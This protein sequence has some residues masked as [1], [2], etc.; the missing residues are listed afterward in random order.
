MAAIFG[1]DRWE[2]A[3]GA[4]PSDDWLL[5][6]GHCTLAD[7]ARGIERCERDD[8]GRLPSLG[9]FKSMCREFQSGTFAGASKPMPAG[10]LPALADMCSRSAKG[11]QWHAYM[12]LR[13]IVPMGD[14][15]MDDLDR[16]LDGCDIDDMD[17]RVAAVEPM[18]RAR[19]MRT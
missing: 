7:I 16:D 13:G 14:S 5:A 18:I 2:R 1:A 6:L 17:R 11:R 12:K 10:N 15:T 19:A 4:D 8:T 9:Q 3:Y